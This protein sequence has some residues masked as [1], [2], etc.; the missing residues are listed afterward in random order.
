[1]LRTYDALPEYRKKFVLWC[2]RYFIEHGEAKKSGIKFKRKGDLKRFLRIFETLKLHFRDR[3]GV[4]KLGFRLTLFSNV[5]NEESERVDDWGFWLNGI[6]VDR[7]QLRNFRC[8]HDAGAHGFVRVDFLAA[9][10][11]NMKDETSPPKQ[12]ACWGFK[13]GLYALAYAYDFYAMS[14]ENIVSDETQLAIPV[15]Q[16]QT[17]DDVQETGSNPQVDRVGLTEILDA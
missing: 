5:P 4:L 7:D 9:T 10:P 12:Q 17:V 15:S 6:T 1:M 3:D 16:G 2:V 14:E 11:K 8:D 13:V